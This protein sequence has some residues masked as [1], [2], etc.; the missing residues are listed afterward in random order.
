MMMIMIITITIITT[1]TTT[2]ATTLDAK[3][4]LIES[5]L[6]C[7]VKKSGKW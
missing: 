1:T 3:M 5:I 2:T 7:Y 6:F 4:E